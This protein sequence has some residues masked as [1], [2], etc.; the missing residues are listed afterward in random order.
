VLDC[1]AVDHFVIARNPEEDTSLPYLVRIPLGEGGVVLKTRDTWPRTAKL[2]CHPAAWPDDPEILQRV[3]VRSCRRRGASIDLVLDRGRE[4]RSQFV[5]ARGRGRQMIFWQTAGVAK[6]ARPAVALPT[7]R[8]SGQ[9]LHVLVDTRERYP[10]QFSAQQAT[11]ARQR[12]DAGD[13]AVELDGRV[14]AAVERKRIA[15]LTSDLTSG[16]LRQQVAELAVLPRA[17]VVVEDRYSALLKQDH[18]R[19]AVVLEALA[20][21]A[22]RVPE[23]PVVFAETRPLAQEWSYRFLGAA[24]AHLQ[25]GDDAVDPLLALPSGGRLAAAPPTAA[26]IREWARA[27]DLEVSDRGKIPA[28]VRIAYD[29]AHS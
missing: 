26:E 22:V 1:T 23:V 18:V 21:L 12:L 9:V 7:A 29:R 14:V 16:R 19:P 28:R 3:A 6:Q 13:Y 5:F 4:S 20:E 2:Y 17:A 10:W 24:L 8:A 27:H 15:D 11:T 25:L